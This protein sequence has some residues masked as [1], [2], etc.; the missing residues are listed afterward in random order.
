MS[1]CEGLPSRV[2]ARLWYRTPVQWFRRA[3][4]QGLRA[5]NIASCSSH[6]SDDDIGNI[7]RA[8]ASSTQPWLKR[9][10]LQPRPSPSCSA[11]FIYTAL[12]GNVGSIS[13]EL[14]QACPG[15]GAACSE[16][17]AGKATHVTCRQRRSLLYFVMLSAAFKP[18]GR[19]TLPMTFGCNAMHAGRLLSGGDRAR[20]RPPR[21]NAPRRRAECPQGAGAVGEP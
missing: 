14:Q 18:G 11:A 12:M 19:E 13:I 6:R 21:R 16:W 17:P 15:C 2:R 9:R 20:P 10:P 8:G 5:P 3:S 7:T 1:G 4:R